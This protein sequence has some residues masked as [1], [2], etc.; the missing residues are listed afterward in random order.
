[1]MKI[2]ELDIK[3]DASGLFNLQSLFLIFSLLPRL[4]LG[5][6]TMDLIS[7]I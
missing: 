2:S 1:M 6:I 7:I 4:L 5:F 3:F